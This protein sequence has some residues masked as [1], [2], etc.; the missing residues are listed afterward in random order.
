MNINQNKL[1][2]IDITLDRLLQDINEL[3]VALNLLHRDFE[4][5]NLSSDN[6]SNICRYLDLKTQ[7]DEIDSE[8]KSQI[9]SISFQKKKYQQ[10]DRILD[11]SNQVKYTIKKIYEILIK[12]NE[13]YLSYITE[14]KRLSLSTIKRRYELTLKSDGWGSAKATYL[15]SL[16]NEIDFRKA[17]V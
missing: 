12:R 17:S 9:E 4:E 10:I 2:F 6:Y 11:N 3:K 7:Y 16:A 13:H 15:S 14:N 5:N 8:Y 1:T